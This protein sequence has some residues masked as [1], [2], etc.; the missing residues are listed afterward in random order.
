MAPPPCGNRPS[1]LAGMLKTPPEAAGRLRDFIARC[2]NDDG[3]Y[4]VAPGQPSNVNG[5]YYAGIILHWLDEND[6]RVHRPGQQP[7]RSGRLPGA[8]TDSPTS[9]RGCA[10]DACFAGLRDAAGRRPAGTRSLSERRRR[11]ADGAFSARS[12]RCTA[13]DRAAVGASAPGARRAAD[14]RPRFVAVRRSRPRR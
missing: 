3:G 6:H 14:H 7:R 5:C 1:A 2:R 10:S 8:R 4:G 12:P 13:G 11:V 9:V